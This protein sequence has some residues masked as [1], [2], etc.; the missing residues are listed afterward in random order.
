MIDLYSKNDR[1]IVMF[2]PYDHNPRLNE[3]SPAFLFECKHYIAKK[4]FM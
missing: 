2:K 1:L 3:R 4:P